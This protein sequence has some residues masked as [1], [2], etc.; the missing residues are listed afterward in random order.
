MLYEARKVNFATL[1]GAIVKS[2]TK[3]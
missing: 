2:L 3:L 1:E